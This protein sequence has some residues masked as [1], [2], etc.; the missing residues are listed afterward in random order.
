MVVKRD[1]PLTGG[2]AGGDRSVGEQNALLV[3]ACDVRDPDDE[4]GTRCAED[5]ECTAL[6]FEWGCTQ[7]SEDPTDPTDALRGNC[8]AP[9]PTAA[10]ASSSGGA[11]TW[12]VGPQLLAPGH[13]NFSAAVSAVDVDGGGG[14]GGGGG[15]SSSVLI[16][17]R[18]GLLPTIAVERPPAAKH[19]AND[20]LV[21]TSS[22]CLPVEPPS[23][24]PV[25]LAGGSSSAELT[26]MQMLLTERG[27]APT[28]P[29]VTAWCVKD[30]AA[31][32]YAWSIYVLTPAGRTP[33]PLDLSDTDAIASTGGAQENIYIYIHMY[34]NVHAHTR[35]Y[36]YMCA[37]A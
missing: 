1:L 4:S 23:S 18:A 10:M 17:V 8:S 26:V 3:D 11:C 27:D 20:H 6:W 22:H 13:Y 14:S 25:D 32:S 36:I 21:L 12:E 19:N 24:P 28:A 33:S 16:E 31:M 9:C 29:K 37:C 34:T 2:I 15:T 7:C 5:E 30:D 35:I